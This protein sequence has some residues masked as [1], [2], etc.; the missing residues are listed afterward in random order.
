MDVA[1][2]GA[3]ITLTNAKV[4]MNRTNMRLVVD[5][6][7]GKVETGGDLQGTVNVRSATIPAGK[8]GTVPQ[9]PA[10]V[11][12][13]GATPTALHP[14]QRSPAPAPRGARAAVRS[15]PSP[16]PMREYWPIHGRHPGKHPLIMWLNELRCS[17]A[18]LPSPQTTN[19][20]SLLEFELVSEPLHS[21]SCA[22]A[23]WVHHT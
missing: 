1:S 13:L 11:S 12:V 21:A 15:L 19:N 10:A 17:F 3:V 5:S 9:N 22:V 7:T 4:D 23:H 14:G 2:K 6:A 20:M 8:L 18:T 16:H